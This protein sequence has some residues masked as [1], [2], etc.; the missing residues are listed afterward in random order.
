MLYER[1][2]IKDAINDSYPAEFVL[3]FFFQILKCQPFKKGKQI[4]Y[5]TTSHMLSFVINS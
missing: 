4:R 5:F 3:F 2:E 1:N